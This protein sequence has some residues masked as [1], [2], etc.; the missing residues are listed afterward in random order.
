MIWDVNF[1]KIKLPCSKVYFRFW[2]LTPVFLPG[3]SHGNRSLVGYSPWGLKELHITEYTRNA[4]QGLFW[5][6]LCL[7]NL[8]IPVPNYCCMFKMFYYLVCHFYKFLNC[9]VM[10]NLRII[11]LGSFYIHVPV[12]L[13]LQPSPHPPISLMGQNEDCMK[14]KDMIYGE[15]MSLQYCVFLWFLARGKSLYNCSFWVSD[16]D[17][18]SGPNSGWSFLL[19]INT[20]AKMCIQTSLLSDHNLSPFQLAS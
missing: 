17:L 19:Y 12:L 11:L 8:S 1:I 9:S 3:K 5:T 18:K 13:F 7:I 6:L 4:M 14:F 20:T 10:K 2:Q 16:N 15:M